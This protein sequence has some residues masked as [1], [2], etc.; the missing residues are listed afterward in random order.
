[1]DECEGIAF[2][3]VSSTSKGDSIDTSMEDND[4]E[5]CTDTLEN[6]AACRCQEAC[7]VK[8]M[9]I[10]GEKGLSVRGSWQ[11]GDKRPCE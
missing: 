4:R 3:R 10:K 2:M 7:E 9:A 8:P 11:G 6:R 1:M 5:G